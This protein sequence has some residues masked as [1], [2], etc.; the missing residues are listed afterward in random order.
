MH[1]TFK[2]PNIFPA[3]VFGQCPTFSAIQ[4]AL[5]HT[6]LPMTNHYLN[7]STLNANS[8]LKD[9]FLTSANPGNMTEEDQRNIWLKVATGMTPNSLNNLLKSIVSSNEAYLA[10][11]WP[12]MIITDKRGRSRFPHVAVL[13]LTRALSSGLNIIGDKNLWARVMIPQAI[14][15]A[16]TWELLKLWVQKGDAPEHLQ[17]LLLEHDL[18]L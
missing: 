9:F 12:A 2:L 10:W 8:H 13:A 14:V 1:R 5:G 17:A 4:F 11:S 6:P 3:K 15:H 7:A 18:G 16:C